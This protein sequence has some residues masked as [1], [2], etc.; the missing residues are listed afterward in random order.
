MASLV[1]LGAEVYSAPAVDKELV[2]WSLDFH[3]MGH[4]LQRKR[5]PLED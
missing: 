1:A 3:P 2:F 5:F 4:P